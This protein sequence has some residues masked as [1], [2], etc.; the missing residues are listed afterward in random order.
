MDTGGGV[1]RQQEVEKLSG[2]RMW[3]VRVELETDGA[4]AGGMV[5]GQ[6]SERLMSSPASTSCDKSL[7]P[8]VAAP[9]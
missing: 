3:R 7:Q 8:L 1:R 6:R 5:G 9:F 4:A 2:Q